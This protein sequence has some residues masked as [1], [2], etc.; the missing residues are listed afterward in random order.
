M[1]YALASSD[2]LQDTRLLVGMIL[3]YQDRD[4][5]TENLLGLIP[6]EP[7]SACVPA[8]NDAIQVLADNGIVR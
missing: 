3:G 5:P 6:E 4:R 1:I 8:G 7:L 2:A